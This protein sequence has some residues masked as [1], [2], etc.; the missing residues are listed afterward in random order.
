MPNALSGATVLDGNPLAFPN[1]IA[2]PAN[3]V[4]DEK[5]YFRKERLLTEP[6]IIRFSFF[7]IHQVPGQGISRCMPSPPFT[8]YGPI[9]PMSMFEMCV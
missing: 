8:I 5:R 2:A 3:K 4:D 6:F 7:R 9:L 1:E